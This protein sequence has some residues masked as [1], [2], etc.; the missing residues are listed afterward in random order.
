MLGWL[1]VVFGATAIVLAAAAG[2]AYIYAPGWFGRST[3]ESNVGVVPTVAA[4]PAPVITS[5]RMI[6]IPAISAKAPIVPVT[7]E[8]RELQIP[9]NPK[10]AGWWNGGAKPGA[11]KGT[12]IIAGHINYR[13]VTGEFATIGKLKPG[14][15]VY[16]SGFRAKKA[17]K[18][19]FKVTGVRTYEKKALPYQQIFNQRSIGR[20]AI[21]TCGGP[22]DAS[23][24][25]Y[26]DN[27]VVFAVP[28]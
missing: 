26:E 6:S 19:R 3:A 25:N 22:F 16:V 24:G 11:A 1:P 27:I 14:N 21:V 2:I 15:K 5:P 13:G 8:H 28:D 9:L 23:T 12:A 10:V 20:L 17:V 4:K 7:T 18:V